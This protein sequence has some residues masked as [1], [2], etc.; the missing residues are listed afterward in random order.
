MVTGY[1]N[2][3][4]IGR[5]QYGSDINPNSNRI[6]EVEDVFLMYEEGNPISVFFEVKEERKQFFQ[7]KED[8]LQVILF[9]PNDLQIFEKY[10]FLDTYGMV[11]IVRGTMINPFLP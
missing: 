7:I 4:V 2:F 10:H 1:E 6:D 5:F 3:D 11:N 9:N 8:L